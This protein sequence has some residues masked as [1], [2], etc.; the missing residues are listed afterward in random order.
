MSCSV[1]LINITIIITVQKTVNATYWSNSYDTFW[2]GTVNQAYLDTGSEIIYT[3]TIISGQTIQSRGSPYTAEAQF[4]LYGVNQIT[5][6]DTYNITAT[7]VTGLTNTIS[8]NF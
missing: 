3:W 4:Q 5:S 7:T 2:S 6:A 8:G 1:N